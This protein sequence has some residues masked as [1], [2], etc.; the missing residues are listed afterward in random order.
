MLKER[1]QACLKTRS[2]ITQISSLHGASLALSTEFHGLKIFSSCIVEQN[3]AHELLGHKTT[4]VAFSKE[5]SLFAFANGTTIYILKLQ[6]KEILQTI[7]SDEGSIEILSFVPNTPYIIAGTKEGRVLQF[8]YD[9]RAQLSRLCS[10]PTERL[11]T[12]KISSN[13][14]SAMAFYGETMACSGYGGSIV[15]IQLTSQANKKIIQASKTRI[16]ALLFLDAQLLLSG[17]SDGILRIHSLTHPNKTQSI[18]T[19]FTNIKSILKLPNPNQVLLS[20]E[21][22]RLVL[23]DVANAKVITQEYL[24]FEHEVEMI[25]LHR[26]AELYIALKEGLLLRLELTSSDDLKTHIIAG[27]VHE[28]YKLVEA[29]AML[30][31][32][33]EH[34]RLE[35]LFERLC[36]QTV[37]HL[38]RQQT[39]EAKRLIGGFK[40]IESKRDVVEAIFKDFE[41]FGRFKLL[42]SQ[43]K[44][45]LA[46][47]MSERFSHLKRTP[48]Y[49]KMEE[50]FT[51]A[52]GFAQ[53]QILMGRKDLAQE[54]LAPYITLPSKKPIINLLLKQNREFIEFLRSIAAQD[55][56]K[57]QKLLHSHELFSQIP[58]YLTL[59]KSQEEEL[60]KI[61]TLIKNG[62]T[63][64]ALAKIQTLKTTSPHSQ[65]LKELQIFAKL[66]E[67]LKELYEKGEFIASYELI[68]SYESLQDVSLAQQLE[69]EWAKLMQECEEYAL[70]GDIKSIKMR[71][72]PLIEL[73]TRLAKIGDLL[74]VSFHTKIK[75]LLAKRSFVSAQNI[76]YSYIDIFGSDSEI[77]TLISI[78]EH[79]SAQK[80]AI[81]L[82]SERKIGRNEWIH[83]PLIITPSNL[84]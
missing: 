70:K 33:R 69:K 61:E 2:A 43:K 71:L 41:H 14:V 84:Q 81:T 13:Y 15:L 45:P 78:Y 48:Q 1:L 3:I 7:R 24:R 39:Q 9:G 67:M 80:L 51:E 31:G 53:K 20:G 46:Y 34:K 37:E 79:L 73:P 28:A 50:H 4:A 29:D 82:E 25:H 77:R 72:G 11:E 57:I 35:S 19:P 75:M 65:R 64:E 47:A 18:T 6:T 66:T 16:N 49:K 8:R 83:S 63:K 44:Y 32:S 26:N 22:N 58:S 10:F 54:F 52:F 74:R 56:A 62:A 23:I 76:L 55:H 30:Q 12:Q 42:V 40:D 68:D 36:D 27:R 21:S 38:M 17:G 59:V 5:L 60:L